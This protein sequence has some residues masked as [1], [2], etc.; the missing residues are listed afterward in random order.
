M[1]AKEVGLTLSCPF[2]GCNSFMVLLV[3]GYAA[4]SMLLEYRWL[5][6]LDGIT[7][8]MLGTFLVFGVP[9]VIKP[10][11]GTTIAIN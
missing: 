2:G 7:A 10:L 11:A 1:L 9:A 3:T 5:R 8:P 6:T 4:R